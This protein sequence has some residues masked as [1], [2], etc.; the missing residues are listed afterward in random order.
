MKITVSDYIIENVKYEYITLIN[1]SNME[2]TLSTCGAGIREIKL[3]NKNGELKTITLAPI[4]NAKYNEAYHGKIIGRTSGRM[5]NATFTIEGKVANLEKN[6]Q[7]IDNL[8][9]GST[10]FHQQNFVASIDENHDFTDVKF[11]YFSPDGEG[12]YFGNV[13]ILN[14]E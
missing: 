14:T 8:H 1:K 9:G 5:E 3:P 13:H 10:G 2:M 11:E 4:D 6:N 7:G 12:G